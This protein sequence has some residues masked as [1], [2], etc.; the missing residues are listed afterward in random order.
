LQHLV[1]ASPGH[2]NYRSSLGAALNN[3]GLAYER[4]GRLDKAAS[5]YQSAVEHQ[6]AALEAAPD[7][8]QIGEFLT[9]SKGNLQR[10]LGSMQH[11]QEPGSIAA[12]HDKPADEIE[13]QEDDE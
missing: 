7:V 1:E 6:Q 3:L 2:V 10:A 5:A 12:A 4:T 9:K 13:H 8:A 11:A